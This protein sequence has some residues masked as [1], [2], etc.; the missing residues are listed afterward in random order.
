MWKRDAVFR[1][2]NPDIWFFGHVV[3]DQ[4]EPKRRLRRVFIPNPTRMLSK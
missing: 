1:V 3:S 2:R 4:K